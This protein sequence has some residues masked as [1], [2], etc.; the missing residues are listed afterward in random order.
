VRPIPTFKYALLAA[1]AAVFGFLTVLAWLNVQSSPPET[2]QRRGAAGQLDIPGLIRTATALQQANR[3]RDSELVWREVLKRSPAGNDDAV[4]YRSTAQTELVALLLLERRAAE[5][6]ELVWDMYP[7]HPEKWR[8]LI[9][10]AR[11]KQAREWCINTLRRAVERDASDVDARRA[12]AQYLVEVG[13]WDEAE[14]E[15]GT[16]LATRPDDATARE[17]LLQCSHARQQWD[18]MDLADPALDRTRPA[19]W[20]IDAQRRDASG[21]QAGAE[22]CFVEALRL[23]PTDPGVHYQFAQ[24]LL[25]RGERDR[26]EQHMRE[27]KRLQGHEQA[28]E[29]F[30]DDL[31]KLNARQWTAPGPAMC[32]SLAEHCRELGR[33]DEARGWLEEALQQKPESAEAAQA[34]QALLNGVKR[35]P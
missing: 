35:K 21:D 6:C 12:L 4:P 13:R 18:A 8:L 34:L 27:F 1:G 9:T 22:Q 10:L 7:Q 19:V 20:I 15:A 24:M 30:I 2:I 29:R 26:A 31:S 23:A 14:A 5:A 25:H 11:L 32:V 33:P 28:I 3:L 16:V 17:V